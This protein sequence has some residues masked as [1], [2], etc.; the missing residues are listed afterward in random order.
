MKNAPNYNQL[1][2]SKATEAIIFVGVDARAHANHWIEVEGKRHGDS[3]PPVYLDKRHLADL[4]NIRVVDKGKERARI[5]IAANQ[6]TIN[7]VSE[8]TITAIVEKLAAAGVQEVKIFKGI[9]DT[10]PETLNRERM[11][12]IR[13]RVKRGEGI[14][15]NFPGLI[16]QPGKCGRVWGTP[17]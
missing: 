14:V 5:Y 12:A 2:H 16:N 3:V 8:S 11:E 17:V 15:V 9:T 7:K 6:E 1:P 4:A 13:A 10:Q